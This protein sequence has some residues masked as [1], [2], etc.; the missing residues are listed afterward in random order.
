MRIAFILQ[1][2]IFSVRFVPDSKVISP[3]VEITSFLQMV[4]HS[5]KNKNSAPKYKVAEIQNCPLVIKKAFSVVYYLIYFTYLFISHR[6]YHIVN[7]VH[8]IIYYTCNKHKFWSL[9]IWIVRYVKLFLLTWVMRMFYDMKHA[10][11]IPWNDFSAH[12]Q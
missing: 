6:K 12:Y 2:P 10:Q 9:M 4:D 11:I 7:V 3:R 5:G 8:H 1:P